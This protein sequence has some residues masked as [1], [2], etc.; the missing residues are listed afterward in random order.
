M[1]VLIQLMSS[2]CGVMDL[3]RVLHVSQPTISGH[4]KVLFA[5]GLVQRRR[6]AS[7]TVFVASRKRVERLLEDA[8]ATLA[9]WD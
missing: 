8:R 2:P 7:R 6:M 9:R 3:S 4:V 5:A 1:H